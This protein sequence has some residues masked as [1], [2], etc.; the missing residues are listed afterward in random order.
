MAAP[1][2]AADQDDLLVLLVQRYTAAGVFSRQR[3]PYLRPMP[4][5]ARRP[6]P[7]IAIGRGRG[8]RDVHARL[9]EGSAHSA[10]SCALQPVHL[11]LES[12]VLWR[13]I[14]DA[15]GAYT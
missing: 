13:L 2:G 8:R 3:P 7:S 9:H 11:Q 15:N 4:S 14:N 5:C 12:V 6:K 10:G 1:V